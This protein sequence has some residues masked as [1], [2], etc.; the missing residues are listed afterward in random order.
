MRN[1]ICPHAQPACGMP[2]GLSPA[3]TARQQHALHMRVGVGGPSNVDDADRRTRSSSL[4]WRVGRSPCTTYG[5]HRCS[6][7]CLCVFTT[8]CISLLALAACGW[9]RRCLQ[10]KGL[11]LVGAFVTHYH[12]DH[13]G[14]TPPKPFDA[15]G[16]T[17]SGIRDLAD[18]G[19]KVYVH[20]D[21]AVAVQTNNGVAPS[22]MHRCSHEE[23]ITVGEIQRYIPAP[24]AAAP[25]ATPPAWT[26]TEGQ[27]ERQRRQSNADKP[28]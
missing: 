26:G 9:M 5:R 12:F 2:L 15:M 24:P 3:A 19:V 11:K 22:C 28:Q 1:A 16:V 23:V 20:T 13:T 18:G 10:A 8:V 14:G 27:P 7:E 17:V 21:D 4:Q 25:A 6:A